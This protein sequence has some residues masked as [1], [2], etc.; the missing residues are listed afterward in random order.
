MSYSDVHELEM[1]RVHRGDTVLLALDIRPL[2][3]TDSSAKRDF[4]T[5]EEELPA[6]VGF[7]VEGLRDSATRITD[8]KHETTDDN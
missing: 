5:S 4:V 8:V 1:V 6:S 3:Q 2:V 7:G